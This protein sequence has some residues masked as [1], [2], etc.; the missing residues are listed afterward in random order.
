MMRVC[1]TIGSWIF[2]SILSIAYFLNNKE[3]S[4]RSKFY[5][6]LLILNIFILVAEVITTYIILQDYN[7]IILTISMKIH[8]LFTFIWFFYIALYDLIL[9]NDVEADN[10][11]TFFKENV[12]V[13]NI[14]YLTIVALIIFIFLPFDDLRKLNYFPGISSYWVLAYGG[15]VALGSIIRSL[16]TGKI[17]SSNVRFAFISFLVILAFVLLLQFK[18]PGIA[19]GTLGISIFMLLL[20]F[21]VEN[22]DIK[23]ANELNNLQ[24]EID[25]SN[26]TKSDFLASMSNNIASPV[27]DIITYS[28]D[29]LTNDEFDVE[30]TRENIDKIVKSGNEL[31]NTINNVMD[32][33]ILESGNDDTLNEGTYSTINL[34]K[35]LLSA[36]NSSIENKH[37][38]FLLDIDSNLPSKLIGDYN[39]LYQSLL[40]IL[41]NS[42]QFTNIGKIKMSIYSTINNNDC[43]LVCKISDT[44]EGM[45]KEMVDSLNERFS[46]K[47]KEKSNDKNNIDIDSKGHGVGLALIEKYTNLMDAIVEVDSEYGAGSSFKLTVNQK[48]ADATPIGDTDYLTQEK[49]I[50]DFLDCSKY[51]LLIVDDDDLSLKIIT[52]IM[53]LYKFQIETLKSGRDCIY[54][55]KLGKEYD[56]IFLDHMMHG[57]DGIDTMQK[58]H[59]LEDYKIPPIVVLTANALSGMREKYIE[60]GFDDYLSKPINKE[61]LDTIINKYFNKEKQPN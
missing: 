37:I 38:Q 22:P 14:S 26:K 23:S 25:K 45:Q 5:K 13:R 17:T 47:G 51:K 20:Y 58:L 49:K 4:I 59:K 10:F 34:L 27:N 53:E 8:W 33:T 60:A 19:L 46:K 42:I 48:I 39:K 15:I 21:S 6:N 44:G 30:M 41:T 12:K 32:I 36:T 11:V 40:N 28:K 9:I 57:I 1:F 7:D 61:E 3:T 18:F 43:S 54:N 50:K 29:I 55:I 2:I 24:A 35:D 52:R 31:L 16:T 56:I